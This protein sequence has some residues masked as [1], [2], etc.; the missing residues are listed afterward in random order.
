MT[1][2]TPARD[3]PKTPR[4]PSEIAELIQKC[5]QGDA[6]ATEQVFSR[7]V[8]RLTAL[9]RSR[10]SRQLAGRFDADD[11]VMSAYRSFFIGLRDRGFDIAEEAELWQ[12]LVQITL[13]KL[14]RQVARHR[15]AKR[16]VSREQH[17]SVGAELIPSLPG[18]EPG[19]D[20]AAAIAEEVEHLMGQIPIAGRRI[21][22]LR[23]QGDEI[24][25]IA[26]QVQV[27]ER[28][29][30]RWLDR[31][32]QVLL[33]RD[34]GGRALSAEQ[35]S[36]GRPRTNR[37]QTVVQNRVQRPIQRGVSP[38]PK[39]PET[40]HVVKYEDFVL[41]QMIGM[42]ASGKVY[43]A[44]CRLDGRSYALKFLRKTF[45]NDRR[46]VRRFID[47]LALIAEL[48]H[49]RIMP[50]AGCGRTPAGGYFFAMDVADGDLEKRSNRRRMAV[51]QA[52]DWL[53]Q[54]AA[55]IQ[56]AH[57]RGVIHCDIKPSNLL[58]SAHGNVLV[59]DFGLALRIERMAPSPR[60]AGTPAFMAP[61]QVVGGPR[62]I[63]M[64]TDVYG[65]GATLYALL[66]CRPP[67]A[68]DRLS[69]VLAQVV[70]PVQPVP[71]SHF[72]AGLAPVIDHVCMR[73]LAKKPTDR[74]SSVGALLRALENCKL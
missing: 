60:L 8:N 59:S 62:G 43:R 53:S 55:G 71:P 49:P 48:K 69:D 9:A 21:V 4:K 5:R 31:A 72:R 58:L 66:T 25:D 45:L 34:V 67:F 57:E 40:L 74:F 14:Y 70:S 24:G 47:E 54:A 46:A 50:V 10:L 61:E 3:R 73:C 29:V 23:L 15:T 42:G 37:K 12:L 19:P 28:T 35:P 32:K 20:E 41:R 52:I 13:R 38:N 18:R 17:Q 7:Y 33:A 2:K 30:R 27:N 39:L 26:Q 11:V 56:Y 36:T 68:G 1:K 16:S 64:A 63:S 44:D 6:A 51:R 65:L 22:E